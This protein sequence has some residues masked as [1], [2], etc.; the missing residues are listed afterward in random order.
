MDSM[1]QPRNFPRVFYRQL[2]VC[3]HPYAAQRCHH[4]C[5]L[6][7]SVSPERSVAPALL[8]VASCSPCMLLLASLYA[9]V[10]CHVEA[11]EML[12][13]SMCLLQVAC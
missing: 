12:H 3:V 5:R 1:H 8:S 4:V 6:P 9:S 11:D 13:P 10:S 2:P 7:S